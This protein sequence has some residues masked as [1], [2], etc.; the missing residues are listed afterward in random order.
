MGER[1]RW[2]GEG[3]KRKRDRRGRETENEFRIQQQENPRTKDSPA[4][5]DVLAGQSVQAADPGTVLYLPATHA[6]QS[7]LPSGPV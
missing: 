6:V 7:S 5:D 1:E 2:K 3:V 4:R